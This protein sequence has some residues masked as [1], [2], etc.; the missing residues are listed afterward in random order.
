ML[1]NGKR[2]ARYLGQAPREFYS[3][4]CPMFL[5]NISIRYDEYLNFTRLPSIYILKLSKNSD[6]GIIF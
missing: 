5:T 2:E 6:Y 3:K 1:P 4:V